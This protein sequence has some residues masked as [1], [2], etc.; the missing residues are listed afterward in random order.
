MELNEFLWMQA[1]FFTSTGWCL[2]LCV[3][4][5]KLKYGDT[6]PSEVYREKALIQRQLR[7]AKEQDC[8]LPHSPPP[9]GYFIAT[10]QGRP[11]GT[12]Y[13]HE[14]RLKLPKIFENF[15]QNRRRR[16]FRPKIPT[17]SGLTE[18]DSCTIM[19]L[20]D[21]HQHIKTENE[22]KRRKSNHGRYS[23][24]LSFLNRRSTKRLPKM[25]SAN[26]KRTLSENNLIFGGLKNLEE[27]DK[28]LRSPKVSYA[29]RCS[30]TYQP[31]F[32]CTCKNHY[33]T[34]HIFKYGDS[35]NDTSYSYL[36]Y[37]TNNTTIQLFATEQLNS[38]REACDTI[39]SDRVFYP[40]MD[41]SQRQEIYEKPRPPCPTLKRGS[42][43]SV[44]SSMQA[45]LTLTK[46]SGEFPMIRKQ[47]ITLPVKLESFHIFRRFKCEASHSF[48]ESSDFL[49][50]ARSTN[51]S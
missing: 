23:L 18:T 27:K 20:G 10:H 38:I 44:D 19:C 13:E 49:I 7:Q 48:R 21:L 35:L 50:S 43:E 25:L 15:A 37:L 42:L 51:K 17:L 45:V 31:K 33:Q 9:N 5:M 47:V 2:F 14:K 26:L 40:T 16:S 39:D 46:T 11:Q 12:A 29:R 32:V 34:G 4:H 3:L 8:R 22:I 1:I 6:K 24:G 36:N 41:K 28:P 30:M